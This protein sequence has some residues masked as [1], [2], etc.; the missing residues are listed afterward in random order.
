MAKILGIDLGTT[1]SAMAIV[2]GGDPKILE[3]VEGNR[4]TPSV[5]AM[6][7]SNERLVGLL[8]KRQAITNPQNT[9]ASVKRL[10]GRKFKDPEVQKDKK[11][12]SFEIRE[13]ADG[14]VEIKMGDKWHK[15]E[16]ISAMVLGKLKKDAE[17]KLGE[18]IEEAVITVPAYFDDSQRQAT[19]NAG[20]IAGLKVR[21]IINEPT[22]A[23]L[24]YGIDKQKDEKV[25]VYDFGG[26]TFD[27]SVLEVG[28][29]TVEVKATGGDTHLG[30]DDFDQL[31]MEHLIKEYRKQEG[32]DV[33]KDPLALQR[34]RE[35][36]ERA[37]HELSTSVETEV[38]L[39]YIT[40]DATGSKHFVMKLTRA[41]I[42]E[43][44]KDLIDR[45]IDLVKE[46]VT[47]PTP[48]GAGLQ[49]SD[50]DEILMV[51]GQTRMPM[52]REAVKELFGKEP[53]LGINPDE[54]VAVGAAI[55]AGILQG[56]VK[57][58]LL[59]DVT[60]LSLG[61]ETLGGVFTKLIEK[62]TTIPTSKSQI[63]STAA[64][65]QTSV[66][67]HVLQGEREMATDS[68]TLGRF[69][70]DGLPPSPRGVP[71]VEVSFD[72]D[73]NGILNVKAADKATGKSQSVRIEATTAL[74]KEE[75]EKLKQEALEH[76][77]DDKAKRELVD[78]RNQ[79]EALVYTAEKALKD[80]GDKIPG[81]VRKEIE[82]KINDLKG[83]TKGEDAAKIKNASES[84]SSSLQKVGQILYKKDSGNS[85]GG[86]DEKT[87][88]SE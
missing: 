64:D 35:A 60:P 88:K 61:I 57:D 51:G 25:V 20:E 9:I 77:S 71:Q 12:S 87:P 69:I 10:I 72:I 26:G 28:D 80:A 74:S 27:I 13:A 79:G 53:H 52:M 65:N 84:L 46:V 31:I 8:A 30:G 17:E 50:I 43:L 68:K 16:E 70:L 78:V 5:V 39:P 44:T 29:N 58:I 38:K 49:L 63:F 85:E 45:S 14:G 47:S 75:I 2:E 66:E 37:K 24:A 48:R 42:E 3:N 32:V 41:T 6:S 1:N 15:P 23:A 62:N 55:Q 33:S 40:S 21:R 36:A 86:E 76:A 4:T 11:I 7:K 34:L 67:I 22:A 54:V 81:D 59:L 56:D 83:A 18:S 19:K 82:D 73:A